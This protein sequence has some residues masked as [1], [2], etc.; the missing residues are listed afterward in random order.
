VRAFLAQRM[1]LESEAPVRN[2]TNHTDWRSAIYA[3][4]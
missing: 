3:Q 2:H 4:H 1:Q